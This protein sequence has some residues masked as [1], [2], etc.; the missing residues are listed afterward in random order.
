ML[1]FSISQN[2]E[3]GKVLNIAGFSICERYTLWVCQNKLW[4]SSEYISGSKYARILFMAGFCIC[5]N[6]A[7]YVSI[8]NDYAWICLILWQQ[9]GSE[10]ATVLNMSHTKYSAR[11]LFKLVSAWVLIK[12][13]TYSEP[14]QGSTIKLFR[15]TITALIIF[16]KLHF[17]SLRGF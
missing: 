16:V 7:E 4:Q 5:H 15:K 17:K 14:F 2:S 11:S 3:Y 8:G 10:Y 12:R 6:M 13:W 1:G 9:T